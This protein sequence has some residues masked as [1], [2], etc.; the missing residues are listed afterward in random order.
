MKKRI[1]F[2]KPFFVG[3]K[4]VIKTSKCNFPIQQKKRIPSHEIQKKK[5]LF[6]LD[7]CQS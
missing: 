5:I 1:P 6:V 7:F 3:A 2:A 4:K